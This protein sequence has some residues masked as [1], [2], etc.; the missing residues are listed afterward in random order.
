MALLDTLRYDGGQSATS[1]ANAEDANSE[2][3][4]GIPRF[5]GEPHGLQEYL[6]RVRARAA[7]ESHMDPSEVKKLGPL[8]LRLLE[9]LRGNAFKLAQQIE[10]SKLGEKD[11]HEALLLLFEKSL[12]PRKDLEARELY[13]AGARDGGLLARQTGEAM[14]S[15]VLRRRTW[16]SH[17]QQLDDSIQVSEGILAE[18]MLQNSGL[19]DDQKLMI[20]TTLH[21]KLT[22]D[23]VGNELL[24]QHP[25]IQD[26][27]RHLPRRGFNSFRDHK[28][29]WKGRNR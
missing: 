17:L 26:R 11:G 2:G 9:G 16:W 29:D 10:V 21:G 24:N 6:Y 4:Y 27:E 19:T 12:K 15:Y 20:R 22:V 23:K 5:G 1:L 13:A 25:R 8:G 28:K 3:K 7:R 14:S 18:Q